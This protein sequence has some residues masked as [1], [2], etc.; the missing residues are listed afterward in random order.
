MPNIYPL[1]QSVNILD[2]KII[3]KLKDPQWK[4]IQIVCHKLL[5]SIP[6]PLAAIF[7][8]ASKLNSLLCILAFSSMDSVLTSFSIR[9]SFKPSRTSTSSC[10]MSSVPLTLLLQSWIVV[11]R[12]W[13]G[14]VD[15]YMSFVLSISLNLAWRIISS[16]RKWIR[17]MYSRYVD[18]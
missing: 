14:L 2:C 11:L 12:E 13:L 18:C 6:A 15:S 7:A 4:P 10:N 3:W 5:W 16:L 17:L 9:R 8:S 1:T